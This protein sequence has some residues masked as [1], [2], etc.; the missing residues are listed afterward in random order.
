MLENNNPLV[1]QH[2]TSLRGLYCKRGQSG[3]P[4][5]R[6]HHGISP[7]KIP[8]THSTSACRDA[9]FSLVVTAANALPHFTA[10][11]INL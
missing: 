1:N 11:E 7:G 10:A 8:S 2:A 9:Q 3:N 6:P 4:D 5:R